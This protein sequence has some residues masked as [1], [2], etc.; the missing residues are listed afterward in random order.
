MDQKSPPEP[1]RSGDISP[2]GDKEF[3]IRND[4]DWGMQTRDGI[5]IKNEVRLWNRVGDRY[6]WRSWRGDGIFRVS[7]QLG[8]QN[9]R[10][11]TLAV[12]GF[13]KRKGNLHFDRC[14]FRF[15][16]RHSIAIW[17]WQFKEVIQHVGSFNL[18]CYWS[19]VEL[20]S[21]ATSLILNFP[22]FK[23]RLTILGL[24]ENLKDIKAYK[25]LS[26]CNL[27][28]FPLSCLEMIGGKEGF[29]QWLSYQESAYK[30]GATGDVGS[31]PGSGRSP[32]GGHGNPLQ[33]SCLENPMERS[34]VG[35]SP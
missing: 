6:G 7:K 10:S 4:Q 8:H 30:L 32:G 33:Y 5:K 3:V 29:P 14:E 9:G 27:F 24:F 26:K 15:Q 23:M 28:P 34:L 21:C 2:L 16:L 17:L 22:I 1:R 18:F 19:I 11:I 25:A 12:S 13:V 35:L 20:Q 31:I